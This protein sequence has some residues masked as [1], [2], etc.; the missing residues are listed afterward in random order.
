M[1]NG[2]GPRHSF[3]AQWIGSRMMLY[4][5]LTLLMTLRYFSHLISPVVYLQCMECLRIECYKGVGWRWVMQMWRLGGCE[6]FVSKWKEFVIDAVSYVEPEKRAWAWSDMTGLRTFVSDTCK[7]VLDLLESGYL[8]VRNIV[9]K[10]LSV[11]RFGWTME[12]QL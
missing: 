7:R 4:Q 10:R 11:N 8:R 2:T 6:D 3:C 5:M 12:V 1:L 9:L